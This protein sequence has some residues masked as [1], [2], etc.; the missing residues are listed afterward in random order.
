M[1][2]KTSKKWKSEKKQSLAEKVTIMSV[3]G[4]LTIGFVGLIVGLYIYA[5]NLFDKFVNDTFELTGTARLVSSNFAEPE[6]LAD[7]VV[8]IYRVLSE[9]ERGGTGSDAYHEYFG[10][11]KELG[12]YQTLYKVLNDLA[13]LNNV[14]DVYYAVYDRNTSSLIYIVD[15]DTR[16]GRIY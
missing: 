8:S 11:V 15:P 2:E 12:D 6:V 3:A 10:K 4:A 16:E 1:S 14:D 13:V 5:G 9:E 7:E